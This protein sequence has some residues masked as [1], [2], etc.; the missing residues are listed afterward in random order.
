MIAPDQGELFRTSLHPVH[1]AAGARLVPFGG[2]DMPVQYEGILAEHRSV[3]QGAGIF[4]L[5]HMARLYFEGEAGREL[6]QSLSTNDIRSLAPGRAQYGLLCNERGGILD[7]TVAYNLG[8][9]LLLVV[10]ATNRLKVLSWLDQ[11]PGGVREAVHDATF[12]TAMIGLQGPL[13]EE[14]LQPLTAVDLSGLRYYAG[15]QG[16]VGGVE[17]LIA[18]TGYT[19]ED[20]FELIVAAEQ[21]PHL[22]ELLAARQEPVRP[23]LCGLGARDTLRLEAGMPLYG[24]EITESTNPYEAG[25]GRVVKLEKGEF[26]GRAALAT[27]SAMLPVRRLVGFQMVDNAVPRQGYWIEVQGTAVGEVTSGTFSPTL[28]RNLGLA[29]VPPALAEPGSAIDVV[30]RDQPRRATVVA[31]PHYAHRTRR[32]ARSNRPA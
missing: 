19:G 9:K 21:G 23:T 26:S 12:E 10:N 7:D 22:W 3:R 25:L 2:W 30:V 24:H 31:L 18:R 5:S 20:G 11:Q 16:I 29:Y 15:V 1:L 14:V 13:A 17:A 28:K 4:D 8:D 6:L 32:P 27:L